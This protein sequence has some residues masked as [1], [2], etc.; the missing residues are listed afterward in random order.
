MASVNERATTD[1]GVEAAMARVL[2]AEQA[3]RDAVEAAQ[4]EAAHMAEAARSAQRALAE[5]TRRRMARVR[6]AFARA[7]QG[8][9]ERIDA[10]ARA[11]PAH[12]DPDA[13]DLERLDRAVAVLAAQL[14]EQA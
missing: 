11:L 4:A 2:E 8:E 10:R 7:V 12:D 5:R 13:D 1:L 3:A 9:L 6:D 14:T